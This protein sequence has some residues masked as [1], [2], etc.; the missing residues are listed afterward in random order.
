MQPPTSTALSPVLAMGR[1]AMGT[2]VT[3]GATGRGQASTHDLRGGAGAAR[4][5]SLAEDIAANPTAFGKVLRGQTSRDRILYEDDLY[6]AFRNVKPYARLAGLVIP[7]R[8]HPH[9]PD[10]LTPDMLP[11]VQR[12]K[13]IALEIARREQPGPCQAGD[14]WLRF[15]RPPFHSVDHLHLH[16]L[17]PV[18]QI[19]AWRTIALFAE[20]PRAVDVDTVLRRLCRP[21]V[22]D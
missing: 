21:S 8:A 5:L 3:R 15:H 12:M 22:D 2:G 19:A 10:G 16:V 4:P 11:T 18:S 6:L 7:K 1:A 13:A 9:D 14:L 17:A 20:G